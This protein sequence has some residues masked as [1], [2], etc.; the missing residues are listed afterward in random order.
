MDNIPFWFHLTTFLLFLSLVAL[1]YA[2]YKMLLD[3]IWPSATNAWLALLGAAWFGLHPVMAETVNY[4]IQRG[5]LYCTLGCVAA[6]VIFMRWPAKRRLG[7]Y[8]L[9]FVFALLSKPPAAV[10]PILLFL[11][12]F[13][14]ECEG[15]KTGLRWRKSALMAFPAVAVTALGLWLQSSLTP[16]TFQPS[17]ISPWDYRLT[18]PFVWLRYVGALFSANTSE[19][20]YRPG[21]VPRYEWGGMRGTGICGL[22]MRGNL[23]RDAAKRNVSGCIWAVVVCDYAVAYV[24]VCAIGSRERPSHV[25]LFCGTNPCGCL[26]GR[27]SVAAMDS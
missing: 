20:R 15:M 11:Y 8:L 3:K 16:K 27:L 14:F 26:G 21:G 13:F 24:T 5:D 2:L 23:V 12:V 25:F 6:L 10:F 18:Q 17:L 9:P 4:I 7:L 22:A 1:L 19:C